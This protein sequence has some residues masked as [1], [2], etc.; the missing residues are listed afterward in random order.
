M[1]AAN[2]ERPAVGDRTHRET[3][4]QTCTLTGQIRDVTGRP[5]I[6]D[7]AGCATRLAL[8]RT[9]LEANVDEYGY[10]WG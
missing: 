6:C 7:D 5:A 2:L 9:L 1:I 10:M 8:R 3:G 4:G